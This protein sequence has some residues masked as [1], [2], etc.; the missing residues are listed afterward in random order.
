MLETITSFLISSGLCWGFFC[1]SEKQI[2]IREVTDS[3]FLAASMM[4]FFLWNNHCNTLPVCVG[5]CIM[6]SYLS[7]GTRH[8]ELKKCFDFFTLNL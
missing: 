4:L 8:M 7:W 3:Y 6:F 5:V 2:N 1:I